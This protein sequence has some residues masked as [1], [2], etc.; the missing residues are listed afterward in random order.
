MT[1]TREQQ[2]NDLRASL[3]KYNG[4][5]EAVL[6]GLFRDYLHDGQLCNTL[7]SPLFIN[8]I[9][10]CATHPQE[11]IGV[12]VR[13]IYDQLVAA[14][15]T[16]KKA[17]ALTGIA[18]FLSG[19]KSTLSSLSP[20]TSHSGGSGSPA[21]SGKRQVVVL[22]LIVAALISAVIS[23]FFIRCHGGSGWTQPDLCRQYTGTVSL[24]G[25]SEECLMSVCYKEEDKLAVKVEYVYE[26]QR[27]DCTAKVKT[28]SLVLD[29]GPELE[30]EKTDDGKVKLE[31]QDKKHGKWSFVSR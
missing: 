28:N 26:P 16:H 25:H 11:S 5:D 7:T 14:G 2:L 24:D 1:K 20:S 22:S 29:E 17:S 12:L 31:G 13:N 8:V 9:S 21:Q 18:L 4:W 3:L 15:Y 10:Y 19:R 30:I 27:I 6:S 23:I